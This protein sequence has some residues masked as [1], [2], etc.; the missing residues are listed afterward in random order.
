M[1][2]QGAVALLYAAS[3]GFWIVAAKPVQFY[4][5]YFLPS[6]FL[7]V[8]LALTLSDLRNAGW[9]KT[10]NGTLLASVVIFA[11]F[12][13]VLAAEPLAGR[14]SFLTWTWLPSWI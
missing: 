14:N 4:Y 9:K 13:E 7:L 3:L 1:P 6:T 8:G 5:H 10:A 11:F 2:M 12:Y